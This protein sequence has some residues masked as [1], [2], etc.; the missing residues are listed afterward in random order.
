MNDAADAADDLRAYEA[1]PPMC[2]YLSSYQLDDRLS[3]VVC[4]RYPLS[5]DG[6]EVAPGDADEVA[7]RAKSDLI[8]YSSG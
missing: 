5:G 1:L 2:S 3:F 8:S 4:D 7:V 6:V